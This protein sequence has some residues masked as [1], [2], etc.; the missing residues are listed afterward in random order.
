MYSSNGIRSFNQILLPN[1]PIPYKSYQ[2]K[3]YLP[4]NNK[5]KSNVIIQINF[6]SLIDE[7]LLSR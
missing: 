1:N 4:F 3:V 5:L 6:S 2:N 7:F